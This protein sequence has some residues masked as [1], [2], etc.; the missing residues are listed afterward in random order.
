VKA[1]AGGTPTDSHREEFPGLTKPAGSHLEVQH[2]TTHHIRTT[3][4]PPVAYRPR[5][6]APDSLTVPK[7]EF[8]AM[9]RDGNNRSAEGPLSPALYLVPKTFSGCMPHGDYLAFNARTIPDRYPDPHIQD[10]SQRLSGWTTFSKIYLLRAYHQIR[11]HPEDIQKTAITKTLDFFE[12]HFMSFGLRNA[13]QTFQRYM[14]E[15]LKDLD[16]CFA[17]IADIISSAVLPKDTTNT[18]TSSS[19]NYKITASC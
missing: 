7:A 11:V 8:E 6:L 2:N 18:F 9:L 12:F 1:I 17:Y 4:G 10:Y 3:P 5:R 14:E 15:I 13:A 16:F 19:L